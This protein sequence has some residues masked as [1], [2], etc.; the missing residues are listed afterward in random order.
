[1]LH[2]EPETETQRE[3]ARERESRRERERLSQRARKSARESARE[4]Q[5]ESH[6]EQQRFSLADNTVN[7]D[8]RQHRQQEISTALKSNSDGLWLLWLTI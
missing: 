8:N 2:R 6:R 5:R 3:R 7:T 4:I 1:M